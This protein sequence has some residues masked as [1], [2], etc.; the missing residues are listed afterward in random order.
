MTPRN[1]TLQAFFDSLEAAFSTARCEPKVAAGVASLFA[2]LAQPAPARFIPPRRLP[3]CGHLPTA[4]SIAQSS[5][6]QLARLAST[7]SAI[8]P[9]LAWMV[10]SSG[11]RFASANWPDGHANAMI[12]GPDGSIEQR[13][14][15]AIG[16]SLLAPYVRYPDHRHP[17]EEVYL[18]LTPGRFRHGESGWFEP[19]PG[20]TLHNEPNIEH[21]MASKE[22][23]LLAFWCLLLK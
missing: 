2:A 15:V 10:R 6:P 12:V 19:G 18:L 4:L 20:G 17:P 13:D 21:A 16:A 5:S 7:F 11:G 14:D 23:P 22:M 3:V 8:E 1:P 9:M